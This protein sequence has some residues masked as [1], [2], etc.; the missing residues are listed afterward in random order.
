MP[1]MR[2]G[3]SW[4]GCPALAKQGGRYCQEHQAEAY[5]ARDAAKGERPAHYR[6]ARWQKLRG[7]VLQGE[8][9]CRE[10]AASGVVAAATV[11]D[12]IVPLSAGG[13]DAMSNLQPLC[14]T[15]HNAKTQREIALR[16]QRA[17]RG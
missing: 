8:P 15:C 6:T 11:V 10:C 16:Q 1:T 7:L 14:A 17:A 4:R 12:H 13:T 3:C 5:K 2:R 9:L